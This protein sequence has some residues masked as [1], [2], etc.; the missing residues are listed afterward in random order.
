MKKI[1]LLKRTFNTKCHTV[2]GHGL[3]NMPNANG[4]CMFSKGTYWSTAR[5]PGAVRQRG[6]LPGGSAGAGGGRRG[7]GSS[8]Y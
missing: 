6:H 2:F 5:G 3:F 1:L 8:I 7:P 4:M